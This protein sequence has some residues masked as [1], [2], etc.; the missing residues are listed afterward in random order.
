MKRIFVSWS[1][2]RSKTTALALKSLLQHVLG[3]DA[4]GSEEL[5][6]ALTASKLLP[7]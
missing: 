2:E 7:R 3:E 1:G 4:S 5:R 6:A